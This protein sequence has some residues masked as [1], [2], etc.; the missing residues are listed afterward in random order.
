[1]SGSLISLVEKASGSGFDHSVS[2][3]SKLLFS[4]SPV[5]AQCLGEV[6][7]LVGPVS[8]YS[9]WMTIMSFATQQSLRVASQK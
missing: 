8:E 5:G 4:A 1:M 3:K 7:K 6:E 2:Y 9:D